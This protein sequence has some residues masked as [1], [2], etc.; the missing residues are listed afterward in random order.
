MFTPKI[1][2]LI[3]DLDLRMADNGKSHLA[4]LTPC[5]INNFTELNED[6]IVHVYYPTGDLNVNN[7]IGEAVAAL[8][9]YKETKFD[10]SIAIKETVFLLSEYDQVPK[11]IFVVTN[12]YKQDQLHRVK[13]AI[14]YSNECYCM[15][16][17]HFYGTGNHYNK[18]LNE[19]TS[20]PDVTVKYSHFDNPD[21]LNSQLTKDFHAFIE[22]R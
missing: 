7:T 8:S 22:S 16:G 19:L 6:D 20:V 11:T 1:V 18:S 9:N 15:S 2:S 5:M 21:A 12:R 13:K 10:L 17:F 14:L 3:I 4:N